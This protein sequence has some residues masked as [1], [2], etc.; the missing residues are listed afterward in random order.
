MTPAKAG[1]SAVL[2][3]VGA[4]VLVVVLVTWAASIGPDRVLSGGSIDPV[5]PLAPTSTATGRGQDPDPVEQARKDHQD[6]QWPAWVGVLA[7]VLQAAAV[8]LAA[9]LGFR[10]WRW[11]RQ[12]WRWLRR[13]AREGDAPDEVD[14]EV[15]GSPGQV[16]AAMED[17]AAAQRA[18][19]VEDAEPRNA[20]VACWHRFEDQAVRAGAARREWQTT[21]EFV[22]EALEHVGADRGAV[23]RLADLYRE[24]RFSDHPM[25]EDHRRAALEALDAVHRSLGGAGVRT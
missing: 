17:D 24:A 7:L 23:G 12:R 11:L 9:Y 14:F 13:R 4:T 5:T 2:A 10:L 8:G 15:L 18:A 1:S 16:E 6:D 21:G 25:T 19:L 22:L 20:I 3:V